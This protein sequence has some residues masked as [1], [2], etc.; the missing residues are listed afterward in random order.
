VARRWWVRVELGP[1]GDRAG[2]DAF[3]GG[4]TG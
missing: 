4:P 3:L 2:L 1:P